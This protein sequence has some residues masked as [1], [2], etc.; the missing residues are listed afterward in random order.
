MAYLVI[1]R[2]TERLWRLELQ[3]LDSIFPPSLGDQQY[4]QI[5][6]LS[7]AQDKVQK[8]WEAVLLE[9]EAWYFSVGDL[10]IDLLHGVRMELGTSSRVWGLASNLSTRKR[11]DPEHDVNSFCHVIYLQLIP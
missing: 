3:I 5:S 7:W 1:A 9:C 8:H 10:D 11:W 2:I 4:A 6:I